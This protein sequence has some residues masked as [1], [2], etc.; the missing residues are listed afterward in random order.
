MRI[1]VV[2]DSKAMRII[3]KRALVKIG[4]GAD[5]IVEA[6]NGIE[7]VEA[8]A[9]GMPD[10]ILSDWNMPGMNGIDFLKRLHA[11]DQWPR[12]GFVTSESTSEM[13]ALALSAGALF[14]VSKPFTDDDIAG[15][16]KS[17]L[18]H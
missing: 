1:L 9:A 3:V 5:Q 17:A 11:L 10:L 13:R 4:I 12:F 8:V 16:V 15:A 7:G 18:P 2:D 14:L 6:S